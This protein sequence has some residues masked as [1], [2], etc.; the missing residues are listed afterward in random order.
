MRVR[1]LYFA[2][3]RE[4]LGVDREEIELPAEVADAAGLR[5]WLRQRGGPWAE[6]LAE[7]RAVRVAVNQSMAAPGTPLAQGAEVAFF[8]PVTGG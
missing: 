2:S 7:Q 3:L 6:V 1:I 4:S 8:P 5:A